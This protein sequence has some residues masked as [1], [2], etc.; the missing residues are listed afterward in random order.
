[1]DPVEKAFLT[2]VDGVGCCKTLTAFER[3]TDSMAQEIKILNDMASLE[4]LRVQLAE[5]SSRLEQTRNEGSES[6]MDLELEVAALRVKLRNT[7]NAKQEE[8][9]RALQTS[10]EGIGPLQAMAAEIQHQ[11]Q[12]VCVC[13]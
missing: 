6:S 4:T 8:I 11:V 12:T 3:Q 9:E 10:S 2:A 1:M 13:V 5:A 7:S